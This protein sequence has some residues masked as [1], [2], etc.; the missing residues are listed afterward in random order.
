MDLITGVKANP[1]SNALAADIKRSKNIKT[2][3][4]HVFTSSLHDLMFMEVSQAF[5]YTESFRSECKLS[6]TA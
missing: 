3:I 5:F 2:F 1:L 6:N 4:F